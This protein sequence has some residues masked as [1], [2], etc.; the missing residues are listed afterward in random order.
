MR[1]NKYKSELHQSCDF[2]FNMCPFCTLG[3]FACFFVIGWFFLQTFF[4]KYHQSVKQFRSR[5][6]EPDQDAHCLHFLG[7]QQMAL[8]AK[9]LKTLA[10]VEL[11]VLSYI[12]DPVV[13]RVWHMLILSPICYRRIYTTNLFFWN[14]RSDKSNSS[15]WSSAV[16]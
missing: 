15:I 14:G 5:S 9:V 7:Y 3:N 8:D 13:Q 4:Q 12:F 2:V 11:W 10:N 1:K 6:V 16:V